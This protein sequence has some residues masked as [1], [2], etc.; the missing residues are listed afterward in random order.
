[1]CIFGTDVI[2]TARG[3]PVSPNSLCS[4]GIGEKRYPKCPLQSNLIL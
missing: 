2:T 1:M 4:C 3:Y